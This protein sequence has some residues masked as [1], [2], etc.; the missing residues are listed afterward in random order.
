MLLKEEVFRAC[1]AMA[2]AL[3]IFT[4]ARKRNAV[5]QPPP[6]PPPPPPPEKPPPPDPEEDFGVGMALVIDEPIDE[7]MALA[8]WARLRE[9]QFEP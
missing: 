8:E 1:L 9:L 2:A 6:P 7:P 3:V 4:F 5:H